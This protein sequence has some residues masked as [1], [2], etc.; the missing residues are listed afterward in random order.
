M[1]VK[2]SIKIGLSLLLI[3]SLAFGASNLESGVSEIG[4]KISKSM[5][6]EG[7]KKIAVIE[8]S[9]LN[10]NVNNLGRFLAEELINELMKDKKDKGYEIV[11]R[12]QLNKVLRQLKLSS[13]GLL[14]PKS[15]KAV[16]K[17][18]NVD[19]IVTGSLTD[20]GNDIKVNARIISV[21]SA[22]IIATASTKIP[23]VG[24]VATLMG[25]NSVK[26]SYAST[27]STRTS[28]SKNSSH[29]SKKL[30]FNNRY[31]HILIDNIKI[32]GDEITMNVSIENRT[33]KRIQLHIN[34][35]HTRIT[36]E[37]EKVWYNMNNT[38]F[39][40]DDWMFIEATEKKVSKMTFISDS[41][42]DSKNFNLSIEFIIKEINSQ[43]VKIPPFKVVFQDIMNH[44]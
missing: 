1:I 34:K 10:D 29:K 33:N 7:K 22:K 25:Q 27:N 24:S 35:E 15:M 30:K 21:E 36:N 41:P 4:G 19:A 5:L 37:K 23:K 31:F 43:A 12:R 26:V 44:K 9:D 16:G 42:I 2:Q 11:E 38:L 32:N 3:N 18:L 14:D 13:S 40:S 28:S 20:L 39:R 6:T 17:I 8:F